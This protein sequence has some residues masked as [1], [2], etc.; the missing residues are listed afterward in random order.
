L[1][2]VRITIR[3]IADTYQFDCVLMPTLP[4]GSDVDSRVAARRG[5]LEHVDF[6]AALVFFSER[7]RGVFAPRGYEIV[8]RRAVDFPHERR[9]SP[10]KPYGQWERLPRTE[11]ELAARLALPKTITP[12][13]FSIAVD[14]L[15]DPGLLHTLRS[16]TLAYEPTGT[17]APE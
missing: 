1:H 17:R 14:R 16:V 11:S 2:D 8:P 10:F 13:T 6:P 9:S 3:P 15:L 7:L 12:Y 5:V 4:H